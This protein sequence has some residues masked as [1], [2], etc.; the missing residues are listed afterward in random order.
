MAPLRRSLRLEQKLLPRRSPRMLKKG[1]KRTVSDWIIS[2]RIEPSRFI[3]QHPLAMLMLTWFSCS[4]ISH[5]TPHPEGGDAAH[6]LVATQAA[7]TIMC[8]SA[9]GF[10][11]CSVP[12]AHAS[13]PKQ[14]AIPEH[15]V[16]V[17]NSSFRATAYMFGTGSSLCLH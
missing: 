16:C 1:I 4:S 12:I 9:P 14:L 17:P 3:S 6:R 15:E 2:A 5:T 10:R 13:L 8:S 11:Y 7:I